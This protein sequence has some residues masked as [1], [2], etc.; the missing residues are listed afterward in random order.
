MR[1]G[2]IL[3]QRAVRVA[4]A[5]VVAA[6]LVWACVQF[7]GVLTRQRA[8]TAKQADLA[9]VQIAA[10]AADDLTGARRILLDDVGLAGSPL[11][12]ALVEKLRERYTVTREEG[13]KSLDRAT[14]AQ[15]RTDLG[16]DEETARF[17]SENAEAPSF[18]ELAK[19]KRNLFLEHATTIEPLIVARISKVAAE[20]G[21]EKLDQLKIEPPK[22][23]RTVAVRGAANSRTRTPA[24]QEAWAE[25]PEDVQKHVQALQAALKKRDATAVRAALDEIAKRG[26]EDPAV[27]RAIRTQMDKVLRQATLTLE[28]T[29]AIRLAAL[30]AQPPVRLVVA[31]ALKAHVEWSLARFPQDDLKD[32]VVLHD[33]PFPPLVK[34]PRPV[35]RR[36]L[37]MLAKNNGDWLTDEEVRT[38]IGD[39]GDEKS[40]TANDS[41]AKATKTTEPPAK[42]GGAALEKSGKT[43]ANPTVAAKG[44]TPKSRPGDATKTGSPQRTDVEPSPTGADRK[45][46]D[47]TPPA[48]TA[49]GQNEAGDVPLETRIRR[50]HAAMVD[51]LWRIA[52]L[53]PPP[54]TSPGR[55]YTASIVF[56]TQLEKLVNFT[57]KLESEAPWMRVTGLRI[58]IDKPDGPLLGITLSLEATV[59]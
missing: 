41:T 25:T 48:S 15:L 22:A 56:K 19:R 31:S 28:Q 47:G 34:A 1:F 42:A 33:E 12:A 43:P 26:E 39:D 35:Q 11:D 16:V 2:E 6:A 53:V 3:S 23:T 10:A 40:T 55:V 17:L 8:L 5:G 58:T 51:A 32:A 45:E 20:S 21:I 36:L 59:L 18:D 24:T 46:S 14:T 38:I 7:L 49:S 29:A 50:Y 9:R 44:E 13:K 4:L 54:P 30:R 37:E 27:R 57:H 52:E